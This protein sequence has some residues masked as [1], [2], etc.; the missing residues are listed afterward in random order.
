M[1]IGFH[2]SLVITVLNILSYQMAFNQKFD[3]TLELEHSTDQDVLVYSAKFNMFHAVDA[4]ANCKSQ[5]TELDLE[6][7]QQHVMRHSLLTSFR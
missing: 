6:V 3:F 5:N 7:P 2:G 1:Y 4:G